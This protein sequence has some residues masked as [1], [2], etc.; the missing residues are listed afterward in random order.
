MDRPNS[1]NYS[2][3]FRPTASTS[4]PSTTASTSLNPAPGTSARRSPAG[5]HRRDRSGHPPAAQLERQQ[6]QDRPVRREVRVQRA[7]DAQ[8]RREHQG[9]RVRRQGPA[10]GGGRGQYPGHSGG[11]RHGLADRAMVRPS[12]SQPAGRHAEL[13]GQPQSRR[14]RQGPTTSSATAAASPCRAPRPAPAA[15]TARSRRRTRAATS[16]ATSSST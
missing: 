10:P 1:D 3:D 6:V 8:G 16:R 2:Y 9:V 14:D 5:R 15:T 11:L 4:R 7:P 12:G 13:L